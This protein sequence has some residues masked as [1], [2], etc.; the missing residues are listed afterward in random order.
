MSNQA[1]PSKIGVAHRCYPI[2]RSFIGEIIIVL[3]GEKRKFCEHLNLCCKLQ[4]NLVR[5]ISDPS[6]Q[7]KT[8]SFRIGLNNLT[9]EDD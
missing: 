9:D 2:K 8:Q 3:R 7:P 6:V 1:R 4:A 5:K